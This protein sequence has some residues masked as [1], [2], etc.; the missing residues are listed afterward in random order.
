M[1]DENDL[2]ESGLL[3]QILD[4][5]SEVRFAELLSASGFE[6]AELMELIEC[7]VLEPRGGTEPEW[8]FA[9]HSVTIARRAA[10]LRSGLELDSHALAV[11]L[12]LLERIEALE[13]E[14]REVRCQM[15]R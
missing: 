15:L 8:R 2:R 7:G 1:A 3:M 6:R 11:V 14:I 12:S 13:R 4:E 5:Q 9:S 10:R